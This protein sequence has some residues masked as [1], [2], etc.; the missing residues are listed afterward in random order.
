MNDLK[1][2]QSI[3][4]TKVDKGYSTVVMNRTEYQEQILEIVQEESMYK[5]I[6]DK[7][8]N[9]HMKTEYELQGKLLKL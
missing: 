8:I 2:D 6:M 9:P 4:I 5:K 7:Q 1:A 3:L